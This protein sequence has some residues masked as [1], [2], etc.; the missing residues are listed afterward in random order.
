M[1]KVVLNIQH[2][3]TNGIKYEFVEDTFLDIFYLMKNKGYITD[4]FLEL[5]L[6]EY[7]LKKPI[8]DETDIYAFIETLSDE[9]LTSL[10]NGAASDD[11]S[12]SI[13]WKELYVSSLY[14]KEEDEEEWNDYEN[15]DNWYYFENDE[16]A[17]DFY[18]YQDDWDIKHTDPPFEY[19]ISR[20]EDGD[21]ITIYRIERMYTNK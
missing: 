2:K 11:Y 6:E 3:Y 14:I 8:D 13:K 20:I 12:Y 15:C 9:Q 4:E 19:T 18:L 10:I 21:L 1:T 17:I 16:Q 5:E 7:W